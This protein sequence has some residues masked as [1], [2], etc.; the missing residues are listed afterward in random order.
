MRLIRRELRSSSLAWAPSLR[1]V[2]IFLSIAYSG[3]V[4]AQ[5]PSKPVALIVPETPGGAN[6]VL[7]RTIGQKLQEKWGQPVVLEF[8]PGAGGI[9]A[10]QTVLRSAP[11]GHT[12]G[13]VTAA[14]A[15][16]PTLIKNLPYDT[17]KDFAPV[18][19]LGHNAI[20]LVVM[21]ALGVGDVKGF[22]ALAKRRPGELLYG[23]NGIGNVSHLA[24]EL[25]KSMAGIDM[26]HVPYKG[27]APLYNE[28]LGGRILISFAILNSAM[29]H[30]KTGKMTVLGVSS[31]KRSDVYPEYPPISDTLPGYDIT[32]WTGL[33]VSSATPKPLVQK[34]SAD[35]L[36]AIQAADVRRRLA[37]LGYEPD[38]LGPEEFEAF[39]RMEIESKGKLVRASDAKLP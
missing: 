24:A 17:V 37:D 35:A 16:N 38:P 4:A 9:L 32:T 8:H 5:F 19:R 1:A 22:I 18:A 30:V 33:I 14:H 11:D 27:G 13:L 28:M 3:S 2:L 20:G 15:I 10:M 12:I 36:T 21:R 7:G 6:D 39:I 29:Q 25:F 26:V 31:L 23:T 34:I